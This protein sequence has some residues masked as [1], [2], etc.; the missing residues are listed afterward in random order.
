MEMTYLENTESSKSINASTSN[1]PEAPKLARKSL[2]E[3]KEIPQLDSVFDSINTKL[4]SPVKE[5]Y[6]E[7]QASNK[8]K[9]R[10]ATGS[11]P[12]DVYETLVD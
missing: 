11:I 4:A 10:P 9:S 8:P 12:K 2:L 6:T 3:D 1:D 7:E 5:V